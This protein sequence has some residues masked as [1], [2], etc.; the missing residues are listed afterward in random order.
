HD[1]DLVVAPT[2]L[3]D[4]WA[5]VAR[6]VIPA[7][8]FENTIFVAYANHC[9]AE[10]GSRYLGESVIVSPFGEDLARAGSDE[11]L[12]TARLD[13]AQVSDARA[14]LRFLRHAGQSCY[15]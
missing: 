14:Q 7:R 1:C 3:V 4:R 5:V 12:L 6:Q 9:G 10:S 13:R 8:A 15:R 11:T 2:A